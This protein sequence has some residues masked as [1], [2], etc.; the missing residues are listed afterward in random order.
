MTD[1]FKNRFARRGVLAALGA[2]VATPAAAQFGFSLGGNKGGGLSLDLGNIF[3]TLDNLFG[4]MD[5]DDEVGM[6]SALYP[7]SIDRSGGAYG[8]A[9]AQ[10]AIGQ[11]AL[12]IFALSNRDAFDWEIKITNDNTLNAWALPGGKLA[13][14]KGLLR[15]IDDP[16]ELA[17][18]IAHEMAHAEFSHG[19]KMMRKKEFADGLNDAT[20]AAIAAQYGG[21]LKGALLSEQAMKKLEEPI[22]RLVTSG[23]SREYE[24]AA[25]AYIL[26]AFRQTGHDPA[27]AANPFKLL[28]HETPKNEWAKSSLLSSHPETTAR[29]AAIEAKAADV[30]PP[31]APPPAEGYT[32][33]K[34]SFPTRRRRRRN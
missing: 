9:R 17:A 11:F 29:I 22:Y 8:N 21:G 1:S 12:P 2:A 16:S 27:K 34:Q 10:E 33:I 23:Y 13:I 32:E 19:L 3:D 31:A 4:E 26:T 14:N 25:D 18:V 5:E 7:P 30:P 24:A 15:H 20:R 6:A 28:L